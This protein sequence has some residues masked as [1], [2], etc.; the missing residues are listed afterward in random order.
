MEKS[1]IT[2]EMIFECFAAA[3]PSSDSR[4]TAKSFVDVEMYEN[5][6]MYPEF[7]RWA[8]KAGYPK[9]ATL[10]RKV[11]GEEKL[12]AIWLRELYTDMGTPIRGEDT[13]R[14]IS[15]LETIRDNCD[16]L[17]KLNP[18]AVIEKALKVAI[19][20]EEREAVDIYPEFRDR[21]LENGNHEAA[22]VYQRVVDSEN[23]HMNW[24]K[25]ALSEFTTSQSQLVNA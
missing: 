14:A 19:M 12:H 21:E 17:I 22:A 9:L 6:I 8:E 2:E 3:T 5:Q 10:F 18:E 23:Q 11:A 25:A 24:F 20:V 4:E 7:A 1:Q 16:Q 15:A 13:A